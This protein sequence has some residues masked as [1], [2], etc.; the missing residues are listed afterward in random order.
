MSAIEV[1]KFGSSV[2]A[3]PAELPVAVDEIY[4]YWRAGCRV[5]AVVSAFEGVTDRLFKEAESL[6]APGP[7][8]ATA[9]FV[10][11]G[12][13][14]TATLLVEALVRF[15]IPARL[16]EPREIGLLAEGS[17]LESMPVGVDASALERFWCG[18]PILVLPGFYGVDARGRT[19]L[20][21]RGGSDLS[22]LFLAA[23]LGA[24]CRL[25]KD[26]NGV[27]DADP[28]RER[29]AHRFTALSWATA[30]EVAGPLIQAKALRYAQTRSLPFHVGRPNEGVG[31]LVGQTRDRWA[32]P[33]P[34]RRA[35]RVVVLGCGVVGR[36]VYETLRRYAHTF[37]ICHVV[38]GDVDKY[39]DIVGATI[40]ATVV[41]DDTIDIVVECF[42]GTGLPY[43]LVAAA[44][45]AGKFVVT[46]NKALVAA[47]WAELCVYARG[48]NPQL[49]YS[50]AVGGAIPVLETLAALAARKLRV[51][52]IRG[53]VN[54]T[55]GVVLDA[56]AQGR[57]REEAIALAQ[58]GGFAEADPARDL[59]GRD[60]ADKLA[61]MIYAAFG[62]WFA[63]ETIST[64]GIDGIAG[65]TAGYK[66]IA[67]ARRTAEL[68]SASV[69]PELPGLDT[70]LGQARGAENRVEI[71][72]ENREV[73]RLR[74]QGAG[75][76]PTAVSV[77][78]DLFEVART[79]E[80]EGALIAALPSLAK[81]A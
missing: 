58:R 37:E 69:A 16:V 28:A 4:R 46:A 54:G 30:I 62:E 29:V 17:S 44:L 60:S 9:A 1:L 21:G 79:V 24:S 6:Y 36:G 5:L 61:L 49:F 10:A 35:L 26:V 57:T 68:V 45:A 50:A 56:L 59:S 67:R 14:R 38:V 42:G 80:A 19:V 47:R 13:Q 76:W 18:S 73:I 23:E 81:Q 71:E 3:T 74:G 53:S 65:D 52:E 66:L 20:F 8:Y 41:L 7:S 11:T 34:T 77:V 25:L 2:L 22:A 72:L 32:A 31:T 78:G 43:P 40:D 12:E 27:F 15:G 63:P 70:F 33:S 64:R 51:R 48:V 55:C 75:R 39:A